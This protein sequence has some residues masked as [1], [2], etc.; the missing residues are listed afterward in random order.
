MIQINGFGWDYNKPTTETDNK[1][2]SITKIYAEKTDQAARIGVF[3]D[4]EDNSKDKQSAYY[5]DNNGSVLSI[6]QT[7]TNPSNVNKNADGGLDLYQ[8]IRDENGQITGI[9]WDDYYN[10]NSTQRTWDLEVEINEYGQFVD[11]K[12]GVVIS[13]TD[14][15]KLLS[16]ANYEEAE[17]LYDECFRP[18]TIAETKP[19]EEETEK[20]ETIKEDEASFVEKAL[21]SLSE[22]KAEIIEYA[23]E[24]G[25]KIADGVSQLAG[26]AKDAFDS[27]FALFK[28]SDSKNDRTFLAGLDFWGNPIFG[29][30]SH[31]TEQDPEQTNSKTKSEQA[32]KEEFKQVNM[33]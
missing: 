8:I 21:D 10:Q 33:E 19:K 28:K 1:D 20:E 27:F 9:K 11:I 26:G 31:K 2:G 13:E 18:A 3:Y 14:Y 5:F 15:N 16:E 17:R 6:I 7:D 24:L 22:D 12:T 23:K 25:A 29:S 4:H 30:V 32:K